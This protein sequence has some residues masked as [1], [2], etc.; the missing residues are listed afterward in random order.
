MIP[1]APRLSPEIS[2]SR[3]GCVL[4]LLDQSASMAHPLRGTHDQPSKAVVAAEALNRLLQ[5]LIVACARRGAV[6]D[7]YHVGAIGYGDDIVSSALSGDLA[8]ELLI[9]ISRLAYM[10]ARI[11]TRDELGPDRNIQAVSYPVWVDALH[12]GKTPMCEAVRLAGSIAREWAADFPDSV[13]P[14]VINISDGSATDGQVREP[15]EVLRQVRT[16]HGAASFFNLVFTASTAQ[17]VLFPATRLG[18]EDA[19]G[20]L[21]FELSSELPPFMVQ[22]AADLGLSLDPGARGFA[23]NADMSVLI[24]FLTIGTMPAAMA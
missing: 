14:I 2:R 8:G 5:N 11:E 20:R 24:S 4:F 16:A 15:A 1:D 3:P 9:P 18:I 7:Y 10:P 17:P 19:F 23:Y 13:P 6:L 12:R 22:R 21:L